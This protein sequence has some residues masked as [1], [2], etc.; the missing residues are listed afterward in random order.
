MVPGH[1][2]Y[3]ATIAL[4][5]EAPGAVEDEHGLPLIGP[6]GRLLDKLLVRA[7]IEPT[8]VWK[9]NT[10]SCRPPNNA[11][12]EYPDALVRCPSLWLYPELASLPN[13]RCIVA[14]GAT[15]GTL[16]FSGLKVGELASMARTMIDG[17][18]VIGSWHPAYVLRG[19]GNWA[20]DSIVN[21]LKRARLYSMI[22]G[23]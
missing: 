23:N 18:I 13:L 22:G 9:T 19:G 5:A 2:N 8:E 17:V 21:S 16:W 7:G 4:V 3:D 11:I 10:I 20:A 14:M 6:A 15:A 1:G 12:R